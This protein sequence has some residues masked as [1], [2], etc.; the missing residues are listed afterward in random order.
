M[1]ELNHVDWTNTT[2]PQEVCPVLFG[3]LVVDTV[4]EVVRKQI[5]ELDGCGNPNSHVRIHAMFISHQL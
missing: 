4:L 1:R 2:F 5:L 3:I